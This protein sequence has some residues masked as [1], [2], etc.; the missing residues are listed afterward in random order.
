QFASDEA[1]RQSEPYQLLERLLREHAA[2]L[3]QE[4]D[5]DTPDD[6]DEPP[7]APTATN[8][9]NRRKAARRKKKAAKGKGGKARFWSPHDPDASF[10]HKGLGY[11]V[12]ITETCRN[13]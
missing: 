12:H 10:G 9:R 3:G 2:A 4:S 6:V 5:E 7:S 11:H 8:G 1:V 13:A